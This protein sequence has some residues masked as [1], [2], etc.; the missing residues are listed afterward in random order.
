MRN[1]KTSGQS[2]ILVVSI[3]LLVVGLIRSVNNAY[4]RCFP[5][6]VFECTTPDG[7]PGFSGCLGGNILPCE[8]I[9][10]PDQHLIVQANYLVANVIYKPPGNGSVSYQV[11]GSTQ[12]TTSGSHSFK[13]GITVTASIKQDAAGGGGGSASAS[14]GWNRS[15]TD[16]QS[17]DIKQTWTQTETVSGPSGDGINHDFDEIWLWLGPNIDITLGSSSVEWTLTH[18]DS[19]IPAKCKTAPPGIDIIRPF[20]AGQFTGSLALDQEQ[21]DTLNCYGITAQDFPEILRH[22]PFASNPV[23]DPARYIYTGYTCPY[24][25][26]APGSG[27]PDVCGFTVAGSRT[28]TMGT[29][30]TTNNII[31]VAAGQDLGTIAFF[32][33]SLKEEAVWTWTTT[34]SMST[35]TGTS[36][37]ASVMIGGPA[38]GYTGSELFAI[39]QDAIYGTY[40]FIPIEFS[41]LRFAFKG[42]LRTSTGTPLASSE[43][44]M[45]A[46]GVDYHTFTD[47]KGNYQFWGNIRGPIEEFRSGGI[48]LLPLVRPNKSIDLRLP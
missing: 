24:I 15:D 25:P 4:A 39:H 1:N 7:K 18:N 27:K 20:F 38:L 2:L 28:S 37:M 44:T 21:I 23:P 17:L 13:Q 8:P 9:P 22:D 10:P 36:E 40:V 34:S 45:V 3:G 43:V 16:S 33:A 6:S 46:N 48:R 11:G 30:V 5:D 41:Q 29:Q 31:T 32:Q 26:P 12:W 35:A 47:A 14:Y 19:S 42:T